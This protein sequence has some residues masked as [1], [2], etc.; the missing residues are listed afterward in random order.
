MNQAQTQSLI[1][2]T[3]LIIGTLVVKKGITDA[4]TWMA[5]VGF[6]VSLMPLV[7]SWFY[8]EAPV[9]TVPQRP[10]TYE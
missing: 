10:A 4:V 3:L 2:S 6:V 8:H 9:T 7:W 1:R 5:V